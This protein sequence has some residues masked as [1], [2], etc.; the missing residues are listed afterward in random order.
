MARPC[1]VVFDDAPLDRELDWTA[2]QIAEALRAPLAVIGVRVIRHSGARSNSPMSDF[3][4]RGRSRV[5]FRAT[6]RKVE[7]I[8]NGIGSMKPWN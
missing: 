6:L 8:V 1:Y 2:D 4:A 7:T 3:Q 5:Q